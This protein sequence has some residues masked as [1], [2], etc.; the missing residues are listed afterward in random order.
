MEQNLDVYF[1]KIGTI[2][3][4][5]P[6]VADTSKPWDTRMHA[7][8]VLYL[9]YLCKSNPTDLA[10][11]RLDE[12]YTYLNFTHFPCPNEIPEYNHITTLFSDFFLTRMQMRDLYAVA[13]VSKD[14][15]SRV[16][17]FGDG[18]GSMYVTYDTI[19]RRY[20]PNKR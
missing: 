11:L 3:S 13:L 18:L 5:E 16:L 2:E 17:N 1:N 10:W 9:L 4:L 6:I 15:E 19:R 7:A 8:R 20:C 12:P 14:Y